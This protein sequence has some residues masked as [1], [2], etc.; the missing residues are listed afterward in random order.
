[1]VGSISSS[2]DYTQSNNCASSVANGS[3]C[4]IQVTFVPS[5][6]GARTGSIT[7]VDNDPSSPQ[8]VSLTGTGIILPVVTV[9]P[10]LLS[11]PSQFVGTSGLPQT[12]TVS[13]TSSVPLNIS[14]IA[15]STAD[16]GQLSACGNSLGAGSSCAI[17]IFFDPTASGDRAGIVTITDNAADS[18][19]TVTLSGKGQDFSVAPSGSTAATI[20]AGQSA[21][22]TL[23]V[24]PGG[25]FNQSV[26]FIC[27][28]APA[29]STC[30]V[31][32]PS[33]ALNGSSATTVTVTVTTAANSAGLVQPTVFP[34]SGS[35]LAIWLAFPGLFGLVLTGS[36]SRSRNPGRH[37]FSVLRLL[38]LSALVVTLSAC[39]GGGSSGSNTGA[40]RTGTPA[41][42]YNLT[43]TATFASGS[44]TLNHITTL[45]LVVK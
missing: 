34:S 32:P 7:I 26:S 33:V 4:T 29:Q 18:P 41:G 43:V 13:N 1:L 22:Y 42:S 28:G 5:G 37:L 45:T 14:N 24:A 8:S 40:G 25:G 10:A 30:S 27:N 23:T 20:T 16:F 6:A 3:S 17:G 36:G 39:G 21:S 9:S 11:F 15:V 38:C 31:S 35:R 44:T 12:I 2:G 19:Q